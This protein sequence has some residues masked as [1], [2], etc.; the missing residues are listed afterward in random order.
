MFEDEN[1]LV[2]K[3]KTQPDIKL[4]VFNVREVKKS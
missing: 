4:V 1:V 3:V 2:F